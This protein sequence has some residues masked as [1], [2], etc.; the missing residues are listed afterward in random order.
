MKK[1][2][3]IETVAFT[4]NGNQNGRTYRKKWLVRLS[5]TVM[6]MYINWNNN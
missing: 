3:R 2:L 1:N 4:W 5:Y 6:R